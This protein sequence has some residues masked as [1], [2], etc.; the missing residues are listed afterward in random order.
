MARLYIDMDG[1]SRVRDDIDHIGDLLKDPV[2]RMADDAESATTIDG[3]RS[4]MRDF[5]DE[6]D[7]GIGRIS[8]YSNGVSES[9]E[10]IRKT[11]TELDQQLADLFD[12]K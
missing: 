3:L 8:K 6:W 10:E 4:K 2:G 1:L 7:Y 12:Q 9:L 11:F 5:A